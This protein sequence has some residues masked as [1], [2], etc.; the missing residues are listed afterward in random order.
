MRNVG[1]VI[2]YRPT[3]QNL[4]RHNTRS[5]STKVVPRVGD[6]TFEPAEEGTEATLENITTSP[7]AISDGESPKAEAAAEPEDA[8]LRSVPSNG[9]TEPSRPPLD[10]TTSTL[11]EK[12]KLL[13]FKALPARTSRTKPQHSSGGEGPAS[14]AE[15]VAEVCAALAKAFGGG[16]GSESSIVVEEGDIIGV[17]EAKKS[18]GLLETLGHKVRKLVWA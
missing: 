15:V 6:K 3:S 17:Q 12:F 14:E 4:E 16:K 5:M 10:P 2:T 18:V 1:V 7:D 13:A 11:N 8:N 9:P